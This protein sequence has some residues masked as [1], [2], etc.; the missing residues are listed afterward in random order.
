[1]DINWRIGHWVIAFEILKIEKL[2]RWTLKDIKYSQ[3]NSDILAF[4]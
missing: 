1:M 4:I 3:I 2:G